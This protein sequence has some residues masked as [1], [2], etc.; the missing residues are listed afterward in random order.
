LAAVSK[1]AW[2][3]TG[4][5]PESQESFDSIDQ[6]AGQSSKQ[7]FS[8]LPF[9]SL[10]YFETNL[11][12]IVKSNLDMYFLE[13]LNNLLLYN[14]R[15]LRHK[16][17]HPTYDGMV[18]GKKMF[19]YSYGYFFRFLCHK[20]GAFKETLFREKLALSLELGLSG[21]PKSTSTILQVE[22]NTDTNIAPP[23]Y[24]DN[25]VHFAILSSSDRMVK[26]TNFK[27]KLFLR[28]IHGVIHVTF[29]F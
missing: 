2:K 16:A 20:M 17:S 11:K 9:Q 19:R 27:A 14:Y 22:G 13:Y 23:L 25:T 7:S 8:R 3:G 18:V 6:I 1:R 12:C 10:A 26:C 29:D 28:H 21:S 15:H 24:S 5:K 4:D